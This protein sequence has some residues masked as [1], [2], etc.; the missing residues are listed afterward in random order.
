MPEAPAGPDASFRAAIAAYD[1]AAEVGRWAGPRH[2]VTYRVLGTGPTLLLC[3]GI[4]STYR[5]YA[6]LLRRLAARFRT[7]VFDYPGD[8]PDDGADLARLSHDDLVDAVGGLLDGL[9]V[10][11]AFLVGLSFGST[12]ALGAMAREPRRYPRAA[13]QGAFARRPIGAAERLALGV[14]RRVPGV[15]GSLPLRGPVLRWKSAAHFGGAL[16]DAWAVY[17]EENGRTP[18]AAMAHRA[19]LLAR[20][21]LRP[22]L[23]AIPVD[24]LVISSRDDRIVPAAFSEELAAALPRASLHLADDLGH[25]PHFTH[26]TLLADL[27]GDFL[28]PPDADACALRTPRP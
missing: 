2:R 26:P 28:L 25:Q 9:G 4:A 10:G 3:P 18:I 24:V 6:V 8:D 5:V 12:I 11:R 13:L 1:A 16:P 22:G 17:L 7:V 21:D 19:D 20:L 15:L 27:I 23:G 14:G